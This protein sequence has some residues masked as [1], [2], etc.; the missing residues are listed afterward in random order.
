MDRLRKVVRWVDTFTKWQGYFLGFFVL[1]LMFITLFDITARQFNMFT[2]WAFDVEWF[3][4]V[5][6]MVV[7]MGYA[8]L[9]GA[10]VRL[11]LMTTGLSPWAQELFL[12]IS[13]T[14][15]VIPLLAFFAWAGWDYTVTALV[16]KEITLIGW[17]ALIWPIKSLITI[18][19]V[20][21]LFQCFAEL[22][23]SIYF[24]IKREKL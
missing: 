7:A 20:F 5:L 11:D 6:L 16:E 4:H 23:R 1:A 24:L 13:Y 14:F 19:C 9:K 2:G 15:F 21:M 12:A 22:T 10:H 8:L 3:I 18:G 17:T